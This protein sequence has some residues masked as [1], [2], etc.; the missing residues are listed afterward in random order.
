MELLH[1]MIWSIEYEIG[2]KRFSMQIYGTEQ[3]AITHAENLGLNEPSEVLAVFNY[4]AN[5][6]DARLN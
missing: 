5:V 6:F 3:E 2:G 1:A 4:D